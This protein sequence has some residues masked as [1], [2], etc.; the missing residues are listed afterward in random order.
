MQTILSAEE[1]RVL[2]ANVARVVP[3]PVKEQLFAEA[4][5][6]FGSSIRPVHGE[7]TLKTC[8]R[9][10]CGMFSFWFNDKNNST[11]FTRRALSLNY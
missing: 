7:R 4:T 3:D 11:H 1:I 8:F 2:E 6:R 5:E 9:C 10:S